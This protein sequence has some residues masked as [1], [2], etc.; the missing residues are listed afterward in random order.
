MGLRFF[1]LAEQGGGQAFQRGADLEHVADLGGAEGADPEPATFGGLDEAFLLQL[2][3]RLAQGAAGD[4]QRRGQFGFH[5]MGTGCD[6]SGGHRV[7]QHVQR[8]LA[9]AGLGQAAQS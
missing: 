3:Q 5:Q 2:P 9:Q 7:A 1:D 6:L 8:L 4:R